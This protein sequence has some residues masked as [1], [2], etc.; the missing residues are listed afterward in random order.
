MVRVQDVSARSRAKAIA[1]DARQ[2]GKTTSL[3]LA[4]AFKHFL[5][6]GDAYLRREMAKDACKELNLPAPCFP[7]SGCGGGN[8][9]HSR[10]QLL[11]K[12]TKIRKYLLAAHENCLDRTEMLSADEFSKK[13]GYSPA[14]HKT[15]KKVIE[16]I[17]NELTARYPELVTKHFKL[18]LAR[19]GSQITGGYFVKS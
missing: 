4:T 2:Q 11:E 6:T 1:R 19:T 14:S 9:G 3:E 12:R 15:I 16:E 10:R 5:T 7:R 13:T 8:G 18:K 17:Q